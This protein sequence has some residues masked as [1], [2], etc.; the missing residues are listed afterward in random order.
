MSKGA[1]TP[2]AQRFLNK[3]GQDCIE[4][5]LPQR[6]LSNVYGGN[7][8][9]VM[10]LTAQDSRARK[11]AKSTLKQKV[12]AAFEA[13]QDVTPAELKGFEPLFKKLLARAK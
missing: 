6:I 1:R 7:P 5:L 11:S 10:Q 3:P 13:D 2:V 12:L 9:L 8:D 4:G